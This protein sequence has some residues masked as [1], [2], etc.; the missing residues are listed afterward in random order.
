MNRE[1]GS[2]LDLQ[3]T[4]AQV[5]VTSGSSLFRLSFKNSGKPLEEAMLE[6]TKYF[7]EADSEEL[8]AALADD[9]AAHAASASTSEPST[10]Q[11]PPSTDGT[12]S[13]DAGNSDGME[14]IDPA[15]PTTSTQ[16]S[17]EDTTPTRSIA[18]FHAPSGTPT[19]ATVPHNEHD[20]IPTV[21]H[22]KLH[23]ARLNAYSQ[24]TRLP[25]DAEIE[26][27]KKEREQKAKQVMNV[28]VRY[29]LP[30]QTQIQTSFNREDTAE[31]VFTILKDALRYPNEPFTLSYRDSKGKQMTLSPTGQEKLIPKLGWT[32][33]TLVYV[34]WGENVSEKAK[35]DPCLN[36]AHMQQ[37]TQL[38]VEMP[39][40]EEE[41]PKEKKGFLGGLLGGKDKKG[42]SKMSAEDREEKLKRMMGFGKK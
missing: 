38:K 4:L 36:D 33:D 8:A 17:Q 5:G 3:K 6:I 14:D 27:A 39:K 12:A 10:S 18:V 22:A 1:L 41:D 7:K 19:A 42:K 16:P 28:R 29:R 24:N 26:T 2:F 30:D 32:G 9:Q 13:T 34:T 11:L 35:K 23:Q 15:I 21:D 25:S 37:A 31:N 40:E 20:Y